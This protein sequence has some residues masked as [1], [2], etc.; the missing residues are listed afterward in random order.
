MDLSGGKDLL[1]FIPAFKILLSTRFLRF[2]DHAW[3]KKSLC[4]ILL[5]DKA[6]RFKRGT[7]NGSTGSWS[8]VNIKLQ[9]LEVG[10]LKFT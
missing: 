7:P 2:K 3:K 8:Y 10:R 5:L 6:V 9:V 1:L 4:D